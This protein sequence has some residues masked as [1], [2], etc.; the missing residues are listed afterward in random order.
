MKH[1]L[2]TDHLQEVGAEALRR[3]GLEVDVVPPLPEE[4]LC[5]RIGR[6]EGLIVRSATKVT[7]RVIEAGHNLRV[8]G[9]AGTGVDNIDVDAASR[10]GIIVMN[11][12]GANTIAAA[13]H[14][15]ALLLT[16]ARKIPEAH[17]ALRERKWERERFVGV[18]V[19]GK[20]LGVIGLG[21]IG[22]EVARR[23]LGLRMQV[24]AY[25]PYLSAEVAQRLG[26]ELTDLP[27]LF[28]RSD[29][30]TVH[31]P[32]TAETRNFIG[33]EE[34]ARMKAGVRL[35]NCARGGV[36]NEQALAHAILSGRVAG[37]AV[38]V[39][40]K[41]PPWDSPLLGLSQV[42]TTPHLG[43]STE[44]AQTGVA[45]A[46]AQHVADALIRGIVRNAAN[47]PSVEPE[48]LKE[49]QPYLTLAEKMGSFLGQLADGRMAELRLAYAGE[50]ASLSTAPLTLSVLKGLLAPILGEGQV[51]DVNAPY[52]AR[53]RGLKITES[54]TQESEVY[55]SLL[56][57]EL[58]TDKGVQEIAGTIFHKR[59]PRIVRID[60]YALEA[61]PAGWM[62]VF[63]NRDVPGVIGQIGTIFGS[64]QI[65]IAGMQLGRERP[66]GRAVSI[67]NLD[68][69][70]PDPVLQEIQNLPTIVSAKLVHL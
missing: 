44:E 13:E 60:G 27:E 22:T 66:G 14:T 16:L 45:L 19:Y 51:T 18:E 37:A 28:R 32:L 53:E 57:A 56:T 48:I 11:T 69:P 5:Q 20:T 1:V 4:E 35:I 33:A 8:V 3:E 21:R 54:V 59:E 38:D 24:I 29:F 23:A 49:L 10:R 25:D 39:F 41:E 70:V 52:L 30:I 62:L 7:A 55:A 9:R 67:L 31:T 17:G 58:R 50:V 36:I 43:A 15:L 47:V 63:S 42:I 64:H 2:V 68:G 26:V 40:E 61:A 34:I 65:N 12:P 6:Y 46:I